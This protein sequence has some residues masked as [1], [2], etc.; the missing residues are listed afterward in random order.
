ML[1][2]PVVAS[3]ALRS[4]LI[5]TVPW[6][7]V[8]LAVIA[9]ATRFPVNPRTWRR[10]LPIHLL[11]FVG[12]VWIENVLVVAGYWLSQSTFNGLVTLAREGARWAILRAHI[13]ALVYVAVAGVT[14]GIAYYRA[15]RSRELNVARLQSQLARARLDALN[16]QIRPHFL[17]NT[18]HTIGQLW[19]SGHADEADTLLDHLGALFQRVRQSTEQPL[20]SLRDELEMVVAYLAIEKARFRDRMTVDIDADEDALD[21]AVPPLL[22]Q[23][24]V[25]NAVRHGIARTSD[26]G[27]IEVRARMDNGRLVIQVEDDGP[28]P[29]AGSSGGNGA[30]GGTGIANTRERLAQLFGSNQRLEIAARLP[31]GTRVTIVVPATS[32]DAEGDDATSRFP[33]DG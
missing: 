5:Q 2:N 19:R 25:E 18:L 24:I 16:A 27:R 3:A 26:S 10:H 32:T 22:L 1:G 15:A 12:L 31:A 21:C 14:Q 23:P 13:A 30:N 17:F 28:G 20:V 29:A 4:A 7:P 11:A 33:R 6:I 8:T 9:L